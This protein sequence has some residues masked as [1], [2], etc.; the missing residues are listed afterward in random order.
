MEVIQRMPL[1]NEGGCRHNL[2]PHKKV[3]DKK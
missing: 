3:R 1:L 2:L